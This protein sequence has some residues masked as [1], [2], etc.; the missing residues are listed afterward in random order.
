MSSTPEG[1]VQWSHLRDVVGFV[2]GQKAHHIRNVL[3]K[4]NPSQGNCTQNLLPS[5]W[6]V[7][8]AEDFWKPNPS[9]YIQR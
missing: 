4:A 5:F 8:S 1:K 7:L 3:R 9:I 2:R 6:S